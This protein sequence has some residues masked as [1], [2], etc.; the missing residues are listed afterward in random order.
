MFE[1]LKPEVFTLLTS[2]IY[3]LVLRTTKRAYDGKH[4]I[5][6][7]MTRILPISRHRAYN[8]D[9]VKSRNKEENLSSRKQNILKKQAPQKPVLLNELDYQN[10]FHKEITEKTR[11]PI[12]MH[13]YF[14]HQ[15][16]SI[17]IVSG[18]LCM[19][20]SCFLLSAI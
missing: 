10:C 6:R 2:A 14:G 4:Q 7:G 11:E 13:P 16:N 5:K 12:M 17:A 15:F 9:L 18:V 1:S 3:L 8:Q 19:V 20:D